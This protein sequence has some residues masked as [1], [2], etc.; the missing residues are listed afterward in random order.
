MTYEKS[1]NPENS[2]YCPKYPNFKMSDRNERYENLCNEVG[3]YC[4]VFYLNE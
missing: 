1:I 4:E 2:E 3:K